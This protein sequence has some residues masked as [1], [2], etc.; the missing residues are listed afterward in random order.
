M[1]FGG[2]AQP[3]LLSFKFKKAL[4]F[5]LNLVIVV[6][7]TVTTPVVNITRTVLPI[8]HATLWKFRKSPGA[9]FLLECHNF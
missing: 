7:S 8:S 5:L 4:A 2:V 6:S 9:C 3:A 1:W